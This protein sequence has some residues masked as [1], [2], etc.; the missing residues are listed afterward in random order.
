[1]VFLI[2]DDDASQREFLRESLAVIGYDTVIEAVDGLDGYTK[3]KENKV[4]FIFSDWSMPVLNGLE[5]IA[6]VKA[7]DDFKNIP[8]VMVTSKG[9]TSDVV[10]A[11]KFKVN[12][13][14]VKPYTPTL[15]E[16]KIKEVLSY[17]KPDKDSLSQ[18]K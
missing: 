1:M 11:L 10:I 2:I 4:D 16:Q 12:N 7:N 8:I 5:F 6:L 3:L 15:L 9:N 17:L 13:Y 14:I 18:A